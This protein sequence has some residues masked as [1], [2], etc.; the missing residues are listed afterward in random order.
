MQIVFV[1]NKPLS[2]ALTEFFTGSRC[3]HV[4]FTDGIRFWDMNKIRRR[5]LW[6]GLYPPDRYLL[7]DCPQGITA[8]YLDN[9]L[10]TDESEY[11]YLDYLMFLFRWPAN[12]FG[13][14]VKNAWGVICSELV[15]LDLKANGWSVDYYETP[16][17]ADLEL[18]LIGR[19]NALYNKG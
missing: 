4:G 16:S 7:H 18:S 14:R 13:F 17:P 12:F 3:Y 10:D 11:G 15:Y 1:Y 2:S 19:K 5:R 9:M 8:E 6:K